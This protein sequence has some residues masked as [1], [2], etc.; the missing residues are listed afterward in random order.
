MS[1]NVLNRT[2]A[3]ASEVFRKDVGNRPCRFWKSS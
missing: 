1:D 3:E 2:V